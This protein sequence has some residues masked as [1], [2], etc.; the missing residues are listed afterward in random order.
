MNNTYWV[1][2]SEGRNV[3][4][5]TEATFTTDADVVTLVAMFKTFFFGK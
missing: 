1:S 2:S 5:G 3:A 4:D